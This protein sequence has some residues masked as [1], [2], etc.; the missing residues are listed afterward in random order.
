[1]FLLQIGT[2]FS[3]GSSQQNR[4]R[5]RRTGFRLRGNREHV[6]Q[7]DERNQR[8]NYTG[9]VKPVHNGHPWDPEKVAAVQGLVQ[10]SR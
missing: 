1:M 5:S 8:K 6:R 3:V 7:V 4:F 10:N 9:T 2:A